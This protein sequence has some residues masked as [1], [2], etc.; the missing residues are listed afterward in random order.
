MRMCVGE[1]WGVG[2]LRAGDVGVGDNTGRG[3]SF[4]CKSGGCI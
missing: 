4:Y 3:A 2:V 1:V